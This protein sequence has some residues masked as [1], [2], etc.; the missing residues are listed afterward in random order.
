MRRA[1]SSASR[2]SSD[3]ARSINGSC[4]GAGCHASG[5][6]RTGG[7]RTGV[8]V[9]I[10]AALLVVGLVVADRATS[11][12]GDTVAIVG[13]SITAL[14]AAPLDRELGAAYHVR[15]AATSGMRTDQM[16]QA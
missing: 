12:T 4:T 1:T 9:S 16:M 13:D 14:N 6:D 15:T 2:S 5:S 7:V 11:R 3:G 8:A 10:G